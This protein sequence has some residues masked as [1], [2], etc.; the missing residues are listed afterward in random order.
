[1]HMKKRSM[2]TVSG[3]TMP[4]AELREVLTA[5]L[6]R[7]KDGARSNSRK[8]RRSKRIK[9]ANKLLVKEP[10]PL[11]PQRDRYAALLS[12]ALTTEAET[13]VRSVVGSFIYWQ[14][15]TGKRVRK[16]GE[17]TGKTYNNAIERFI[18]DLLRAKGD[19]KSSGRIFH[20]TGAT[21]FHDVPVGYDVF[22]G[23]LAGLTALGFVGI[24]KGSMGTRRATTFWATEKLV[25]LAT[26][27]GVRLQNI[28]MDSRAADMYW[29]H[30]PDQ[31][32]EAGLFAS[33]H[34]TGF[35]EPTDDERT[36]TDAD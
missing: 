26:Q 34:Y 32:T 3:N 35:D 6:M 14:L 10:E 19:T 29:R 28:R 36:A 4:A 16:Y 1:M 21:T 18:G 17:K 20:A 33:R 13:L 30:A 11:A 23:M 8:P 7:S 12:Q 5:A 2:I 15:N 27:Y 9:R 24:A 31:P 22:K 25:D